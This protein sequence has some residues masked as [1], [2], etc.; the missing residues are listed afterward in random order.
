ML[1]IDGKAHRSTLLL[2]PRD[3]REERS[4][5]PVMGP[6]EATR[7]RAGIDAI[8]TRDSAI[9]LLTR[10]ASEGRPLYAPFRPEVQIEGGYVSHSVTYDKA[11][12]ADPLD[13]RLS[14][15]RILSTS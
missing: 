5:G 2:P 10:L 4:T 15:E 11:N 14:R 7:V 9:P 12:A 1:V 13:G 6:D 3:E 8:M